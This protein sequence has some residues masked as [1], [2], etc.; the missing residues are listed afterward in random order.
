MMS[1]EPR[2]PAPILIRD[3]RF[4][5]HAADTVHPERPERLDAID[6]ALRSFET[7]LQTLEPRPATDAEILHAHRRDH[8]ERL[9]ALA[10]QSARLDPDTYSAPRSFEVA[11]LAAGATIDLA[12]AVARGTAPNGLA[13]IRPPGHHAEPDRAMG[14]C[15]LNQVAIAAQTLRTEHGLERIAILDWDVHHGNGTQARFWDDRDLL[16]L[17][18]H[19]Y[20]WYPGTG[21]LGETGSAGAEGATVNLP[22]PAG[23]GD[24]E[25]GAVFREVVVPVLSEF[26]P[27]FILVSAG[28][29]AEARDP[30]ASMLMSP[31]GFGCMTEQLLEVADEVCEGRVALALEGGYHLEALGA[32]VREVTRALSQNRGAG[33][34]LPAPDSTPRSRK[35]VADFR[36]AHGHHWKTLR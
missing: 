15:L 10:G 20:P 32:S 3:A 24:A 34:P 12:A 13:L 1:F 30:L 5:E 18:L 16:Y 27:E 26:A 17:S 36:E 9:R 21:A 2:D 25:Y 35:L 23:C 28:F 31:E 14:F 6:L 22:L 4:R 7:S 33:R 11:R 8:L 19:Q 29:D